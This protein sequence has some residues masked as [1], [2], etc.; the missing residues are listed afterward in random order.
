M[1]SRPEPNHV[2][3]APVHLHLLMWTCPLTVLCSP[4]WKG[5]AWSRYGCRHSNCSV[6]WALLAGREEHQASVGDTS[7]ASEEILDNFSNVL[8]IRV[9][10]LNGM[11]AH[12][13]LQGQEDLMLFTRW[14]LGSCIKISCRDELQD[15]PVWGKKKFPIFFYK[16]RPLL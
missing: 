1:A 14:V 2:Q 3:S 13:T 8:D 9:V 15:L 7:M 4:S 10:Q 11:C 12:V 6:A 5:P 16:H